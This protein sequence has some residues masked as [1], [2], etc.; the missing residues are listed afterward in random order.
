MPG[1]ERNR[2]MYYKIFIV[3]SILVLLYGVSDVKVQTSLYKTED[4]VVIIQFPKAEWRAEPI[5][6]MHCQ[7]NPEKPDE[8]S[9]RFHREVG[10]GTEKLEH[11]EGF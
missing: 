9:C 1:F 7:K 6:Y 8:N 4:N 2:R 10:D 3:I 11:F 5:F